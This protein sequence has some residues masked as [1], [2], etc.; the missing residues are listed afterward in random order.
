MSTLLFRTYR[1]CNLLH[2]NGNNISDRSTRTF[3]STRST[4]FSCL[5][6]AEIFG[7][8]KIYATQLNTV[9]DNE[10]SK[11]YNVSLLPP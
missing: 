2:L 3:E 8:V 5:R 4:S 7:N 6:S 11:T 1:S 9:F 10:S